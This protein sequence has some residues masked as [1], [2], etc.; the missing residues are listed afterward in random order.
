MK[1]QIYPSTKLKSVSSSK[2]SATSC[3][4][5]YF[6]QWIL[7][8]VPKKL[9]IS[10]W[11]GTVMHAAFKAIAK[12]KLHKKIYQ[13]MDDASKAELSK[14]ALVAEDSSEIQ[15][16]LAIA[17]TM[18]KVYLDE[19][20][21]KITQLDNIQTEVPFAT[22]LIE[23]PITYY[24]TIDA[25]GTE[26]QKL[27]MTERKTTKIISDDFFA[28]LK[29]DVQINMY[30]YALKTEICGKYPTRCNYTAFRKPQIRVNKNETVAQFM[31]RLEEDLHK[32]KEWYYVTFKH[33]FGKRSISEVVA[34]VEQTTLELHLKYKRL[35]TEQLLN[36]YNW[37]RRRSHCLWYGV[38]PYIILC[39]NCEKYPLYLRLF[40]QRE[41]RYDLEHTELSKKPLR[42]GNPILKLNGGE[43]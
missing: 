17:K 21:N 24:G 36:P 35:T 42:L 37:P 41:L 30:A 7:N 5:Y 19:Y 33:N 1:T 31:K 39:K 8:L 11:F 14:Y 28:L 6:W 4:R 2:L 12:P 32:R 27:V 20:S 9:N 26:K 10:L 23:S 38:C 40:Q 34:D 13:I 29:F 22:K 18:I 43:K 15:L 25:Y 16:Q 3:D